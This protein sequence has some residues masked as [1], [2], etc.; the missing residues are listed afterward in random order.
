MAGSSS[1]VETLQRELD[2]GVKAIEKVS[3][4]ADE[5]QV[6]L[7]QAKAAQASLQKALEEAKTATAATDRALTAAT[8]PSATAA[9]ANADLEAAL[10]SKLTADQRGQVDAAA[11]EAAEAITKREKA[12]DDADK[13]AKEATQKAQN[14][15]AA[16]VEAAQDLAKAL[17]A[18]R[19]R[20]TKVQELTASVTSLAGKARAALD[21]NRPGAAYRLNKELKSAL[22][23]LTT[24][25]STQ[26][27]DELQRAV[28]EAWHR[29]ED[30]R[31]AAADADRESAKRRATY[32]EAA[33]ALAEEEGAGTARL[34]DAIAKLEQQWALTPPGT[35][36]P[37][38]GG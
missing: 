11:K 15:A 23:E 25:T 17:A 14:A 35:P 33:K 21:G 31:R 30:K 38:G 9:R 32:D 19:A 2:G 18:L 36:K 16:S 1:V 22:D 3:T 34:D 8:D 5:A 13:P 10:G 29:A 27:G 12:R 6:R 7:S 28:E 4:E 20:G 26:H 37:P 24:E